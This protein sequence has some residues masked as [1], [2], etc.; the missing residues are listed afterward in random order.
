MKRTLLKVSL[1]IQV[2][3]FAFFIIHQAAMTQPST[4]LLNQSPSG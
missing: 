4:V 3:S 2:H 1:C